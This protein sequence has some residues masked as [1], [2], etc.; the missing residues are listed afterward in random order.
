VLQED[1]ATEKLHTKSK[2]PTC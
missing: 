1:L 2:Y